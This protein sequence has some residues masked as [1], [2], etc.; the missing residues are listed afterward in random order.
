MADQEDFSS[1]PLPDRF[2]HKVR[3]PNCLHHRPS[4]FFSLLSL[5]FFPLLMARSRTGKSERKATRMLLSSSRKLQ[6]KTTLFS[7]LSL[8]TLACGKLLSPTQTSPLNAKVSTLTAPFS[9]TPVSLL[10]LAPARPP[11]SQYARRVSPRLV[12]RQRPAP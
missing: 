5:L 11:S 6:T 8:A 12:L 2:S 3:C 9:N 10:V 7:R 4:L 1:L